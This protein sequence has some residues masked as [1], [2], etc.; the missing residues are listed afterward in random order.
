MMSAKEIFTRIALFIASIIISVIIYETIVKWG[1]SHFILI[2]MT[3]IRG[4]IIMEFF[5]V[6]SVVLIYALILLGLG[7]KITKPFSV[8]LWIAYLGTV[9]LLLF[10]RKM[11]YT[12]VNLDPFKIL[13]ELHGMRNKIYFVG[14]IVF[15][16]PF[17]YLF[18]KL[19]FFIMI[20]VSLCM[21]FTIEV[22]QHITRRGV[23]DICDV[24]VNMTGIL[25]GYI[26]YHIIR[27]I[28]KKKKKE[29]KIG[30]RR[31]EV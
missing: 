13:H 8:I 18:R 22:G 17:G 6:G 24:M 12:E 21:E 3:D 26:A 27:V 2:K 23:C 10:A 19:N 9:F 5:R 1:V 16:I 7:M 14:N 11:Q 15:F 4:K 31:R 28:L 20:F 29:E 25:I 30:R